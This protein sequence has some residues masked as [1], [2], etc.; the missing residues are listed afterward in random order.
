MGCQVRIASVLAFMALGM[1]SLQSSVFAKNEIFLENE[2]NL[3]I[4]DILAQKE[5]FHAQASQDKFVYALLYGLLDKQDAGFYLEIGAGDPIFIN[6]S[7]FLEKSLKWEGTSIEISSKYLKKWSS[8]R[9]NLLLIEDA[10]KCDYETILESFPQIID[11]LSLDV[12][13]FYT[14]VLERIPFDKYLFKIITIEHDFYV[15][16]DIYREKE[17]EVLSSLGYHLLCADVLHVGRDFEDWWIHPS[18]FPPSAFSQLTSLDLN[19]KDHREV[20]KNILKMI[21]QGPE[22]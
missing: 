4:F 21:S 15:F 16:G 17:R 18:V 22:N 8:A 9:D 1:L 11:Y 10:T 6:N 3:S 7:Y 14:D 20:I 13:G 2:S 19:G 12:D 5:R